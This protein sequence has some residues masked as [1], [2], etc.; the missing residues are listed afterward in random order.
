MSTRCGSPRSRSRARNAS[1]P[2]IGLVLVDENAVH[3]HQVRHSRNLRDGRYFSGGVRLRPDRHR[4]RAGGPAGRDPGG[5]AR[6]AR[7]DRREGAGRRRLG[8]LGTIPSKTLREAIVYLTGLSQRS[9]YGESYRVKEEISV[10]DLRRRRGTSSTARSTS[11][12]ISCAQPCAAAEGTAALRRPH[13][14]VLVGEH[15]S[16]RRVHRH[17][18][19]N[20]AGPAR[21]GRLRRAAASSTPTASC[22]SAGAAR[23][24]SSAP[25]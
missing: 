3:V 15:R 25:A 16:P 7:R 24:S 11:S 17:R 12:A 19:R 10:D 13:T 14:R 23:C 2:G 21:R 22:C 9:T 1:A 6:Q 4:F 5:Q 8:E 18:V 20:D